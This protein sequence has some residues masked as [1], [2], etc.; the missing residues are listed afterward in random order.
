MARKD[1]RIRVLEDDQTTAGVAAASTDVVFVP[2]FADTNVNYY[3]YK[4]SGLTPDSLTKGAIAVVDATL[5]NINVRSASGYPQYACN[6]VDQIT[7]KC[8]A[9]EKDEKEYYVWEEQDTYI[10]PCPENVPTLCTTL[11]AFESYFGKAP[12]QFTEDQDVSEFFKGNAMSKGSKYMYREGDYEKSYIYAKELVAAGLPVIDENVVS[13]GK[14]S[15]TMPATNEYIRKDRFIDVDVIENTYNGFFGGEVVTEPKEA[16][17]VVTT[18]GVKWVMDI[19]GVQTDVTAA[20]VLSDN[21]Q[22]FPILNDDCILV[23]AFNGEEYVGTYMCVEP[24]FVKIEAGE[25]EDR[26]KED[27]ADANS[28]SFAE[29]FMFKY[30]QKEMEDV[31]KWHILSYEEVEGR[32]EPVEVIGKVVDL[33]DYGFYVSDDSQVYENDIIKIGVAKWAISVAKETP[34]VAY[35]Y[36]SLL[37]CYNN[38]DKLLDK[39]EYS[40][41]YI[42]S[43]AYPTYEL[44]FYDEKSGEYKDAGI[45]DAMINCAYTRGDAFALIDHSN[46][47]ERS[48]KATDGSGS[49]Y[50][51]IKKTEGSG[52]PNSD[53]RNT[54]ATMFTPWATYSCPLAPAKHTTQLMPASFAYLTGMAQSVVVNPNW[55]AIAGVN[56]GLAPSI[57]ALNTVERLTNTIADAYQPRDERAINAITNIKPYGLTIW[58]NRTLVSNGEGNLTGKSFLNIRSLICDIKKVAYTAAKSL[59]FEQNTEILWNKFKAQIMPTL[60]KMVHGYGLSNYKIIKATTKYNGDP[61]A[62]GEIA[63]VI[64][65]Y[66]IYA[67]EDF[68]ITVVMSDEGVEVN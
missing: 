29:S 61:L 17:A 44:V 45:V 34:T 40:V 57:K 49:V 11:A 6:T 48:L 25:L 37:D 65:I 23:D 56:R 12:Y 67:V 38:V 13:R 46:N 60:D 14:E 39:G 58:G 47:P 52:I 26:V 50:A 59:L 55:L 10:E 4:K 3:I 24:P 51:H 68:E 31:A 42:T 7:W 21:D 8:T 15:F 36:K 1:P 2:G 18:K 5:A 22:H 43:G 27:A 20:F 30:V 32:E 16:F 63:A 54:F 64:K 35:L 66:P 19:D 9:T 41:K 53:E 62:K 28:I 33:A